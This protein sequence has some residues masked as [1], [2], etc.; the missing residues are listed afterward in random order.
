[1]KKIKDIV[2]G[3]L[4]GVANVIPGASGGTI[5][6]L[7]GIFDRLLDN[8]ASCLKHPFKSISN[9]LYIIIG[10]LIGIVISIFA[11]EKLIEIAPIP[12]FFFF[13]GLIIGGIPFLWK[14]VA[15]Q[16]KSIG[17]W[18]ILGLAMVVIVGMLFLSEG[19]NKTFDFDFKSILILFGLGVVSLT[20]MILP[21]VSGSM[22]L[23]TFGYY[24]S[25]LELVTTTLKEIINF[26]FSTNLVLLLSFGLGA[27]IGLISF[28]KLVKFLLDKYFTQ[29]F[30]GILGLVVASSFSVIFIS[31]RDYEVKYVL[32][33][34]FTLV[35][36]VV[37]GLLL[38][39]IEG[40]AND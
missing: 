36:G 29:T 37:S 25:I 6:V 26:N 18:C 22:I 4:L 39:K 16:K 23:A 3:F 13:A 38:T 5:A 15:L 8:I 30:M 31:I 11:V 35:I 7:T 33:G 12:T 9:L 21:G 10:V 1:M 28:A 17:S 14:K 20:A 24:D 40:E 34:I 2:N 19:S 32:I 27:V